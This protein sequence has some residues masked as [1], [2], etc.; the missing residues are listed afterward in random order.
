LKVREKMKPPK[1]DLGVFQKKQK[2]K[3]VTFT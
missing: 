2:K 3:P 1:K